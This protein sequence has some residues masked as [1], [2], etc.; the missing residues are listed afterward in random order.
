MED[1]TLAQRD[2]FIASVSRSRWAGKRGQEEGASSSICAVPLLPALQ[3]SIEVTKGKAVGQ[4][5]SKGPGATWWGPNPLARQSSK[6]RQWGRGRIAL[7]NRVPSW[8]Y[9]RQEHRPPPG[10]HLTLNLLFSQ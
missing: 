8:R 2:S 7:G 5:D 4:G 1:A 10:S 6:V 9:T 3:E